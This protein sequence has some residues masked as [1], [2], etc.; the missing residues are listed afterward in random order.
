MINREA[1]AVQT[2]LPLDNVTFYVMGLI[3]CRKNH[4]V[5]FFREEIASFRK[6]LD[7]EA[8]LCANFDEYFHEN[9]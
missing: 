4:V 1:V 9:L 8:L 7:L 6:C 3:L 2:F 5:L